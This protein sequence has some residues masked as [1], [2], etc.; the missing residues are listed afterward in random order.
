MK[1]KRTYSASYCKP[2]L[3]N[4]STRMLRSATVAVA[5]TS[6]YI[7]PLDTQLTA[8]SSKEVT[9]RSS[10]TD[11][12]RPIHFAYVRGNDTL[13]TE[14]IVMGTDTVKGVL[15]FPGQ[16]VVEWFQARQGSTPGQLRLSVR[17][18]NASDNAAPLQEF[19]FDIQGDSA[20]VTT[21]AGANSKTDKIASKKGAVPLIGQSVLHGALIGQMLQKKGLSAVSLFVTNGGLTIEGAVSSSGDTVSLSVGGV[22]IRSI[23]QNGQL[24]EA[25]VPMQGLRVVRS[26]AAA[27][28]APKPINYDAPSDAPYEALHFVIPTPRGYSL[29]ATLTLPKATSRRVP[30]AV[31][32]SGSG[33]QERDSR[34][35]IV[36]G[37]QPFREIAD[38]LGRRGIAVLRYDDRGVGASGGSD[39]RATATSADFADDVQSVV[40]W[41]RTRPEI[42]PNRIALIGHSE[43][44]LIAPIVAVRDPSIASVVLMAGPAS[45]GRKILLYQNEM[46]IRAAVGISDSERDSLRKTVPASLDSLAK[47]N[48]WM[49]FF[50]ETNPLDT[51]KRVRQ[52]VLILQ[53]NTD[54]QVTPD[55]ADSITATL[56]A[57]GNRNVVLRHFANTNHLFL[58]DPSGAPTG[59][60][61]L[62]NT[63]IRPEVLGTIAD[64]LVTTLSGKQVR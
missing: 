20:L 61:G 23:W 46:A 34:I 18:A 11:N 60:P 49:G 9:A 57:S 45:N 39:S 41:L 21:H 53:G 7:A 1:T 52:P 12:A 29:A 5:F 63:H 22:A 4:A 24:I 35:S 48:K 40:A 54:Q 16:P 56:R 36:P 14:S 38:T 55:Q 28:S 15:K 3:D 64:W 44:G 42:D 27:P 8:Q 47:A 17:A 19:T 51:L 6:I 33:P 25:G 32:I 62:T 26:D 31:T 43:G 59:Y 2:R 13:A 30:V 10:Q 58:A 37:Y 50:M